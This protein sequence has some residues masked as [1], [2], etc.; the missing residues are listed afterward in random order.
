MLLR[1]SIAVLAVSAAHGAVVST[2]D[3]DDDPQRG[4]TPVAF[5]IALLSSCI[6]SVVCC[7]IVIGSFVYYK[8]LRKHPN[9]LVIA[10]W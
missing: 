7:C 5:E 9:S 1:A 10:R 2:M 3:N 8:A 6:V 4:S